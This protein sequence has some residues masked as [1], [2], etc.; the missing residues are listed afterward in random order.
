VAYGTNTEQARQILL[1]VARAH[2][3]ILDDPPPL[4]TFEQFADSSLNLILRAYLPDLDHR[5]GTI[6]E[7]HTEIHR[8]FA[9]AG[10]E[11]AF[12]QRDVHVRGREDQIPTG[13]LPG[14]ETA[15]TDRNAGR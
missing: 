11:I 13:T 8:R 5:L 9:A 7:L 6:T 2:P 3:M 12:P 1:D 14:P 4:A 10:I 15:E